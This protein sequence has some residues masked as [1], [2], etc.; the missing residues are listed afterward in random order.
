M[1]AIN[2]EPSL[3]YSW[4]FCWLMTA[5]GKSDKMAADMA[6][7]RCGIEFLDAGKKRHS[8]AII[9]TWWMFLKPKQGMWAQ[10]GCG[11]CQQWWQWQ[12]VASTGT[13]V[14]GLASRPFVHHWWKID[15]DAADYVKNG[16]L[17]LTICSIKKCY[18]TLFITCSFHGNK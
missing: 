15:T 17:Y 6:V 10:C 9:D 4:S 5:E 16:V 8:L 18:C 2:V 3:Q 1:L 7:Q 13:D 14:Y 12:W 11:W